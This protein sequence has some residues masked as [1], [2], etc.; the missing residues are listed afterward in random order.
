MIL[1]VR[2]NTTLGSELLS[3]ELTLVLFD[4]HMNSLVDG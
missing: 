2:L 4:F 1:D 3:T